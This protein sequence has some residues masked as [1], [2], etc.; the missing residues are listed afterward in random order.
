MINIYGKGDHSRVVHSALNFSKEVRFWDVEDYNDTIG[1]HWIIAVGNNQSRKKI[2][3]DL[4]EG[5]DYLTIISET[6]IISNKIDIAKGSQ[7]LQGA[8]IQIGTKIGK[9][10]IVNTAASIDHD[11]ILE[12]FTFVGPNA[13]LC[14]GVKIGEGSFIGAGTVI[15]PYIKIGKNCMI[16]AGSVVTKDMPDHITA[17][18]NPAVIKQYE[19][20]VKKKLKN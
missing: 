17:Y 16:G 2:A 1:G 11:C 7:I 6:A 8:V 13:T 12:D 9:H 10:C 5:C 14:G 4:G 18:G 3:E 15:L 20:D 19:E